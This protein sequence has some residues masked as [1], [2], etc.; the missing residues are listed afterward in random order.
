ML[1]TESNKVV[2]YLSSY[3]EYELDENELNYKLMIDGD[4]ISVGKDV[5]LNVI[6]TPGHTKGSISFYLK[7]KKNID[8]TNNDFHNNT[9]SSNYLF[10]GDTL[11][12]DGVGRPDLRDQAEE[13]AGLLHDT[14]NKIIFELP[15]N[16][17]ILPT[18]FN[19][20]SIT[21]KH[22]ISLYDTLGS[23]RKKI[24]LLSMDKDKFINS[25]TTTIPPKPSNYQIIISINK[26]MRKSLQSKIPDLEAGPNSCA[27]SAQ[28]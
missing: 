13:F 7:H 25:I 9:N 8:S 3:E 28:T 10:T 24:N 6:H 20:S 26:K 22:N 15:E 1:S 17:M 14:Y 21:L 11:F 23:L 16:I 2:A 12:I 18:H 5:E 19:V 27:I 4:K